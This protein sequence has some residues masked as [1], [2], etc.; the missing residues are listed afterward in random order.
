MVQAV[1]EVQWLVIC[2]DTPACVSMA[3]H[4]LR[5]H[6]RVRAVETG[7]SGVRTATVQLCMAGA[8]GDGQIHGCAGGR[9]FRHEEGSA[10][11]DNT[12]DGAAGHVLGVGTG[13]GDGN[14][15][16]YGVVVCVAIGDA[17]GAATGSSGDRTNEQSSD[18][19][20]GSD[21]WL[22]HR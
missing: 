20:T 4:G 22:G 2:I 9:V 14:G 17:N 8:R 6:Q 21:Q 18:G 15:V 16:C 1:Y 12:S 3:V 19:G 7:V 10:V 5:A 11:A 13:L